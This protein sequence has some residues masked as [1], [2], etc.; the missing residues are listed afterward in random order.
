MKIAFFD[1]PWTIAEPPKI[2]SI[3]IISYQLGL[4][5]ARFHD[6]VFYGSKGY[7][8][9]LDYYEDGIL[10]RRI[11]SNLLDKLLEPLNFLDSWQISN[12]KRPF[13]SSILYYLGYYWQ[14]AKDLQ[15]QECDIVHIH[16]V[17][18]FVSL[19]KA[20]NPKV[21]I[22]LHMH[23]EWLTQFDS[24][25][26]ERQLKHV[27]LVITCSDYITSKIRDQFPQIKCQTIFNGVD[28]NHFAPTTDNSETKANCIKQLLFV[29]RIS[30][31]KG[32][33]VLLDAFNKVVSQYP[34]VQLKL[35]GPENAI[36]PW[37]ML[38][39]EDP[40]IVALTPFYKGN[41]ISHLQA[42]LCESAASSVSFIGEVKYL[43]LVEHYQQADIFIFPSV[44]NEPF[45]MPLIEAMAMELP[46]ITT[47]AGAFPEIVEEGKT[48]LLV[49]RGDA[50]ALAESILCLLRDENLSKAMG[51]AGRQRTVE[52][53]SWERLSE[54]L[55]DQY[56]KI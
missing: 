2:G 18:Q 7:Y 35:V 31:E 3:R 36:L 34:Q 30:P 43:E 8:K 22:V 42:R 13:Y 53:F 24:A 39:K 21:K 5:F 32:I 33:H 11:K 20:F 1:Y 51:K 27:D 16:I 4:R 54:S 37:E 46:V 23:C 50:D 55:F 38:D 26:V 12:P 45:G 56:E 15:L 41:Y 9:Q 40:N 28:I 6:V 29:G 25:M 19:I 52:K 10:Y 48:G 17:S 49:E 47:R 44:W 14:I